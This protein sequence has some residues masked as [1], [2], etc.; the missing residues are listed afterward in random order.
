MKELLH[1]W[2]RYFYGAGL[3]SFFI[4]LLQL[5]FPIYMMAIYDK[6]LTSYSMPTLT[7]LTV[8]ALFAYAFMGILQ[9]L[10]ARVLVRIGVDMDHDLSRPVFAETLKDACRL[11]RTGYSQGLRDVNTVRN[12]FGGNAIFFIFDIPWFPINLLIIFLLHPVVGFVSLGGI[13]AIIVLGLLQD[14]LTRER[15]NL[16]NKTNSQGQNLFHAGLRNAEVVGSMGMLPGLLARWNEKNNEVISLQTVASD[17]AGLLQSFTHSLRLSMQVIIYGV[18][19][20]LVLRGEMTAGGII[21][22]SILMGRA[23]A[24]IEQGMATWKMTVEAREAWRRLDAM[25]KI[26]RERPTMDLP[27]PRGHLEAAN[28][29]LAV[30]NKYILRDI[31]FTLEPG[32]VLAMVGPSAAG[33][34]S[35]CRVL[36]GIWPSMGGKVRLDGADVFDWDSE[37]L[38]PH[39]G[40]LPQDVELFPGTISEN[41]ARLGP[42]DA[43]QVIAAATL[44]GVH[45]MI[46]GLPNGYDTDIGEAGRNLSG[47]QRQRIGLAR[48]LY[49]EPKLVILDEP[50]SNLDEAGDAALM[51]TLAQLRERGVT[52][53]V[54]SHKTALLPA[55]DK[56]L[57]LANGQLAVFGPRDAVLEHLQKLQQQQRPQPPQPPSSPPS[58]PQ[59]VDVPRV[60]S[61]HT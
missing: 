51:R 40:Y 8:G 39:I 25:L 54:V 7:T 14:R 60:A 50:N 17:K 12:F 10:R 11:Q 20:Y 22:A 9:F 34:S 29:T 1:K 27:T 3:F 55:V 19:A 38:G 44:A 57:C 28:I 48:A 56:I 5:T 37:K 36:L 49:G 59:V 16:A 53:I 46:L 26:A 13:T 30:N 21:A 43:E 32:E 47:G 52:T 6:V 4:N 2:R 42:V 24:P 45:E 41:I 61:S 35:L 58:Q 23:M 15:L 33:K 31:S 18:G